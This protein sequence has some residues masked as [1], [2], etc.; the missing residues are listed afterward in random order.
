MFVL[1]YVCI[2]VSPL[3]ICFYYV[4]LSLRHSDT[5]NTQFINHTQQFLSV[6][7]T[8]KDNAITANRT[9]A[10]ITLNLTHHMWRDDHQCFPA[11]CLTASREYFKFKSQASTVYVAVGVIMSGRENNLAIMF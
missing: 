11:V 10:I 7:P 5:L 9:R 6:T 3:L 8:V 4:C 2:Y 1:E